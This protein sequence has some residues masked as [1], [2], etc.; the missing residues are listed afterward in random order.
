MMMCCGKKPLKR[1]KMKI[2]RLR[3][4]SNK[5]LKRLILKVIIMRGVK[6]LI[7]R[8][9]F[10]ISLISMMLQFKSQLQIIS[11]ISLALTLMPQFPNSNQHLIS[12]LV[13]NKSQR[14]LNPKV[15][16]LTLPQHQSPNKLNQNYLTSTHMVKLKQLLLQQQ[17][18]KLV[19]SNQHLT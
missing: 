16:N 11:Q 15:L 9:L 6:I 14:H 3:S 18:T 17:L 19:I 5:S 7:N 1:R 8:P 10:M 2:R 13:L 4:K 12:I